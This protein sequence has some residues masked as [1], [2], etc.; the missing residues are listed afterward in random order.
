MITC[1]KCKLEKAELCFSK[2]KSRFNGLNNI[3]KQCVAEHDKIYCEKNKVKRREQSR[4]WKAENYDKD[5]Q[6]KKKWYRDNLE[7][8]LETA[9][10][11][12]TKNKKKCQKA[13]RTWLK[14][15]CEQDKDYKQIITVKT[16]VSIVLRPIILKRD[17][18]LCIMCLSN[19]SK[20]IVHHIFPIKSS[21]D[22][23]EDINN[24]ITL[25]P[26][27]HQQAHERGHWKTFDPVFAELA[28][29]YTTKGFS[30]C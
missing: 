17:N 29:E 12:R 7:H 15:K 20:L 2:D 1:R 6:R 18:N 14:K 22:K 16:Y 21:P 5:R 13:C 9:K 25:C 4:K 11:Y 3:C 30:S 28:T 19:S 27:C 23:A 8:T 24:L 26:K 10:E